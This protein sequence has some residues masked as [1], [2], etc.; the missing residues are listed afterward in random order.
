[1]VLKR[2]NWEVLGPLDP[3]YF[4]Y[5]EETDWLWRGRCRGA[6][7]GLVNDA[8]V[9][10]AFGHATA[11][12]PDRETIEARSRERFRRCNYGLPW[13]T[14]LKA[15]ENGSG[16]GGVRAEEIQG[17]SELPA[18]DADLWLLSPFPHLQPAAGWRDTSV[19]PEL[20]SELTNGGRWHLAAARRMDDRWRLTGA[21]AWG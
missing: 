11:L 14:L 3:D 10:H 12:L 5:Y 15:L 2:A 17:P 6:R 20:V 9:M 21:W 8:P 13:R 16:S 18:I 1:M 19:P 4:L 7:V